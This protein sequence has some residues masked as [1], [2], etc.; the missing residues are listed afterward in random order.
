MFN[1]FQG[2][3]LLKKTVAKALGYDVDQKHTWFTQDMFFQTFF[4]LSKRFGNPSLF[5]DYK[6]AGAWAFKVKNYFIEIRMN[7]SWVEFMIYGKKGNHS[8]RSPFVVKYR[9]ERQKKRELLL[10]E[11]GNWNETEQKIGEVLF[12]KF[13]EENNI[14]KTMTQE[15]FDKDYGMKWYERICEY[16]KSII[17]INHKSI[18]EL[19][20]DSYQNSYTRHAIRTLNQFLNNMLTPI[21]IMDVPYN[22]KGKISDKE[23]YDYKR[24]ENNIKIEFRSHEAGS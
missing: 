16:N 4:Y 19:Y 2:N 13:I 7:S 8:V 1:I 23:A 18:T 9:R 12:E 6:E 10:N 11:T 17:N 15:Q 24:F 22:I 5:D 14:D 20:G 3:D 21:W